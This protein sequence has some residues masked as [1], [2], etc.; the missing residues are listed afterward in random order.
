VEEAGQEVKCGAGK[1]GRRVSMGVGVGVRDGGW[2]VLKQLS[3]RC[4][5]LGWTGLLALDLCDALC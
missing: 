3:G 2:L 1:P 5:Q 4:G